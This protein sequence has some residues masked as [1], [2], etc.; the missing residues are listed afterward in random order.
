MNLPE[1]K[2]TKSQEKT[3]VTTYTNDGR[4]YKMKVKIRHDDCCGNGHNSFAI[5]C[6]IYERRG[7]DTWID[8]GGGAAHEEIAK[9]FPHLAPFIK[10]HLTST[11]GPMHYVANSMY[12]ASDKDCW[13][14]RKGEKKQLR[15]GGTGPLAWQLAAIVDGEERDAR[16]DGVKQYID[17]DTQPE[18]PAEGLIY[19]PWC[20]EGEGKDIDLEAARSS[21]IWPEAEL[22]DFTKESLMARLPSLM[23][24]FKRA[25][26]EL[27]LE[28]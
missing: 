14:L 16:V 18:P 7:N 2:L 24:A 8:V 21:A 10:W 11:D 15:K 9:H 26:E 4:T 17:S 19:A 6:D 25:V 28:Y 12:H 23:K 3:E 1:S 27:G 22:E 13:G 20:R 5:T